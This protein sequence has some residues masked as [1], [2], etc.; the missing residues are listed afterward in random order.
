MT[1]VQYSKTIVL[2]V[3]KCDGYRCKEKTGNV[4]EGQEDDLMQEAI[5]DG[6]TNIEK[7]GGI[8]KWEWFCKSCTEKRNN[9]GNNK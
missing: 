1:I 3:I 5:D 7:D 6:F 9:K 4:Y 2:S 8:F